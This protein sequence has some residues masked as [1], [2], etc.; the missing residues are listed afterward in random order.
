MKWY[1]NKPNE[2]AE[3]GTMMNPDDRMFY[4]KFPALTFINQRVIGFNRIHPE[5]D[6]DLIH[7]LLNSI[8]SIFYIE[9]VGFGRGLGALDI[10]KESIS[11]SYMLNPSLLTEEQAKS[12]KASFLKLMERG[13]V[14]VEQDLR[15]PLRHTFDTTVLNAYG[16]GKYYYDIVESLKSMRR[17]RKTARL[18]TI[19]LRLLRESEQHRSMDVSFI[20]VVTEGNTEN[21]EN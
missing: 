6:I 8:I 11:R 17:M 4:V 19:N 9:A 20:P 1:E 7:A 13:V 2:M 16:I 12:I 10:S 15:D 21:L 14:D 5:D 3:I 18:E